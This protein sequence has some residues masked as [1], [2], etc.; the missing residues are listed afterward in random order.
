LALEIGRGLSFK[1]IL[2]PNH[3]IISSCKYSVWRD[4]KICLWFKFFNQKVGTPVIYKKE[5]KEEEDLREFI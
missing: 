1:K 5:T 2:K 4:G 3:H